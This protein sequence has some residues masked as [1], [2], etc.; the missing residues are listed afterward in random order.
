MNKGTQVEQLGALFKGMNNPF[1]LGSGVY[2]LRTFEVSSYGKKS[3]RNLGSTEVP[4]KLTFQ[5]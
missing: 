3:S 5:N 2:K 1:F 4:F